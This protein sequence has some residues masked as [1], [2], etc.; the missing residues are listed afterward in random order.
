[1]PPFIYPVNREVNQEVNRS[2]KSYIQDPE[3]LSKIS[4]LSIPALFVF[5]DKDIRPSWPTRQVANLMPHAR[6]ELIE[7]AEHV[8][9]HSHQTELRALLREFFDEVV[10]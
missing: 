7:G 3:L 8:I 5:G 6:F 1:V 10:S 9:W 2:W 4:R